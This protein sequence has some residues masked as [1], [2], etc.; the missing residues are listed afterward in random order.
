MEDVIE[1]MLKEDNS[2]YVQI[3]NVESFG[4]GLIQ[5]IT[6][7]AQDLYLTPPNRNFYDNVHSS[8]RYEIDLPLPSKIPIKSCNEDP[9]YDT[10]FKNFK[11]NDKYDQH[12]CT[13]CLKKFN[14]DDLVAVRLCD[15]I[16]HTKCHKSNTITCLICRQ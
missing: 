15:H 16:F 12:E 6:Y 3:D 2:T 9:T 4:N 10:E 13:I 8:Q 5:L 7:G 11:E 1:Q 14:D